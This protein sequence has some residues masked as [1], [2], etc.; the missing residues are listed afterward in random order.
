MPNRSSKSQRPRDLNQLVKDIVDIATGDDED[1]KPDQGKD[2]AAVDLGRRDGL[3]GGKARC[4]N[5]CGEKRQAAQKAVQARW[6]KHKAKVFLVNFDSLLV[7][8]L[9]VS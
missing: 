7:R 5:D 2:P 1:E 9:W 8:P 4:E 6:A 3:K